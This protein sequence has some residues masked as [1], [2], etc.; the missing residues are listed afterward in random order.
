M[1]WAE[2]ELA[3]LDKNIEEHAWDGE[4]YLRAYRHDGLKFG[5]KENEE[6]S[7]FL[8]PQ[9]WAI[10]SGHATGKR[11]VE[12]LEQVDRRLATDYGVALCDPPYE[13]T[14]HSV[15]KAP[16]FN[17]GMKEN[18]AIF[19]HTQGWIVMALTLTGNGNMAYRYYRSYLPAA[20]NDRAEKRETEPY[21]YAQT[22]NSRYNMRYGSSRNP[23]LSGTTTW[24][25]YTAAQY[26]LGI[27]PEYEALIIDPCIP[28]DWKGFTAERIFRNKK[29]SIRVDNPE[30]I[31]K[32]VKSIELNGKL[33]TGNKIPINK[34]ENENQ[35]KVIMG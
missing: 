32:G 34:L 14:E 22:T 27:R 35:V 17:K 31:Q 26:I 12:V 16:L 8:N 21:V 33:L 19:C 13:K 15:V 28:S 20:F 4:W 5:S 3:I 1:T 9:S 6:G 29:I 7:I 30:G 10:L 2:K 23:W 18:A 11:A 25:Y 24:A